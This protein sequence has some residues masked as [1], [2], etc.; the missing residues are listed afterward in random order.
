M[1]QSLDSPVLCAKNLLGDPG[2]LTHVVLDL[3]DEWQLISEDEDA[4]FVSI[5]LADALELV[6]ELALLDFL[7][8]GMI[9]I[10]DEEPV[11][12]FVESYDPADIEPAEVAVWEKGWD[13]PF[14]PTL[15]CSVSP[16]LA[17][18]HRDDPARIR[19]VCQIT[20]AGD[21]DWNFF[22]YH[23]EDSEEHY[24]MLLRDIVALYPDV[25]HVLRTHE[26]VSEDVVW[27][28]ETATWMDGEEYTRKYGEGE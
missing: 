8:P 17:E 18:I 4:G 9:A 3:D 11:T 20:R 16:D 14:S 13:L 24:P 21:N 12:W 5:S 25:A 6:P 1:R 10:A 2:K 22:G 26:P 23:A 28:E 19:Q 15:D 27:D 7:P